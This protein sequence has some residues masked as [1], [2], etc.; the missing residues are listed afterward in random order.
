MKKSISKDGYVRIQHNGKQVLEHRLI[1]E[2]YV[3]NPDNKPCVNHKNGIKSD[4]RP[5]NL[6]W[7]TYSENHIHAH[8]VL[9]RKLSG[10]AALAVSG[11]TKGEDCWNSKLTLNEI[12]EIKN[13]KLKGIELAKKFNTSPAN[14]SLIKNNKRWTN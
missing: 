10:A 6:E 12:L 9:K 4:N 8:R 1:A 3:P 2:M 14:I 5:D 7:V 13:S 11:K